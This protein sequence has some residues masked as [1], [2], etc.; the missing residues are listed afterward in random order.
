MIVNRNFQMYTKCEIL[1]YHSFKK[2]N[3]E[4]AHLEQVF[5]EVPNT[6]SLLIFGKHMNLFIHLYILLK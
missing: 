6:D 3:G 5:K 4:H 2:W 1:K